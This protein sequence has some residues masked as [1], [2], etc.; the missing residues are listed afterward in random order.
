MYRPDLELA[1][2]PWMVLQLQSVHCRRLCPMLITRLFEQIRTRPFPSQNAQ[3]LEV[4]TGTA[5]RMTR[6]V[7]A[8]M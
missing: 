5:V 2:V 6:T 1:T 4:K 8:P 3:D 7:I